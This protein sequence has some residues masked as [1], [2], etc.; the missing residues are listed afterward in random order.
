M[1]FVEKGVSSLW[2]DTAADQ[3]GAVVGFV[4][5]FIPLSASVSSCVSRQQCH[6]AA[7][8]S[9]GRQVARWLSARRLEGPLPLRNSLADPTPG[10]AACP[11]LGVS[12]TSS[13]SCRLTVLHL[14]GGSPLGSPRGRRFVELVVR[15]EKCGG[16]GAPGGIPCQRTRLC[17]DPVTWL[18]LPV[19]ICLSQRLSHACLSTSLRTKRNCE[20][21]I[22]SVMV[23]LIVTHYLDNCGN[24]RANTCE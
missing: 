13:L 1:G 4:D 10:H 15:T 22:K 14:S 20:W 7:F 19:V 18:I 6:R 12:T 2:C 24:S 23:P 21:L 9:G 17:V 8:C 16:R 11:I 5:V 3:S